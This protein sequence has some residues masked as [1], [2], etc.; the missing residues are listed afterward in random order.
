MK[1]ISLFTFV[2]L[3]C[4]ISLLPFV[5]PAKVHADPPNLSVTPTSL[6]ATVEL[7]STATLSLTVTNTGSNPST[8]HLYTGYPPPAAPAMMAAPLSIPV[9]LPQQQE[10]ID[11]DLQAEL[12]NGTTHFLVFFADRPDL[13]AAFLIRDWEA[14]GE[15]VYQ[16]L[17]SHAERSQRRVRAMLD[18]LGVRYQPLWIVNALLVEGDATLAQALAAHSDV[19]MLTADHEL[20]MTP[21]VT[22]STVSCSATS[23][24]VCWNIARIGADRVWREFGVT[25]SGITV[26]NIDSGVNY[27]HPAL[28][29]QYR[30]NLGGGSFDHNYNWFDPVGNQPAPVDS[31]NHGTHVMG[32]MVADPPGQ[33]AMGVAP[34]AR[35]IAARA[36]SK[37]NCNDSDIIAAAQWMLAPTDLNGNNPRP[38]LRPHVLNNSWAFDTGGNQVY[39]GYATAWQAAGIFVVFAAGNINSNF[40]GCSSV[41]SPSDYPNVVA[42]GATDQNDLVTYF[43]RIGPTT[44]GRIKPDL[45]APGAGIVATVSN[46]NLYGSLSGTSMAAPHVAGAVALLWAAKPELIGDYNATYSL[47]TS[48]ALPITVDNRYM[49]SSHS[50]CRPTTVPNN[51]YGYGRLDIFKAV[52]AARVTVPWLVLPSSTSPTLASNGSLDIEITLDA[53]RVAGPG[54][55]TARLLIYDNDLTN[56]PIVVPVTMTVPVRATHATISGTV[57]DS[58]T[59][60]PLRGTVTTANG[61]TVTTNATGVYSMTVPGGVT[62]HLTI[63]ASG[64]APYTQSVTPSAGSSV[65]LNAALDP[66]RPRLT[67]VQDLLTATVDFNQTT[68]VTLPLRNDGNLPL[69]YTLQ[70]DPEPYGVWRSDEPDGPTGGW[71]D[72]P[73][74]AQNLT[75]FDDGTSTG[76]DL[77][78]DFPFGGAYYRTIY[79]SA[80]GI[81][82][83]APFSNS[84]LYFEPRCLPLAETT[85]PAIVPL[86]VDF[87]S[88]EGGQINIA[89]MSTGALI[90]WDNVP[91]YGTNR[92]LSVQ[93]LLQSNGII[94]FHYRNVANL[95]KNDM[96]AIGLQLGEV[97][98]SIACDIAGTKQ[99]PLTLTDGLVVELRP[100]INPQVWLSIT[101]ASSGNINTGEQIDVQLASRWIG[102]LY[103]TQQARLRIISNDPQR[104]VTVARIRLNEGNPAPYQIILPIIYR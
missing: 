43:S 39:S 30:G 29:N 52:A 67:V 40:T 75:L 89:R 53:R 18:A 27:T 104:P 2:I 61:L 101:S 19:A 100:Q 33:P 96:G 72:P 7:G 15:Y 13:G 8:I 41:A 31:G 57:T 78:F 88:A 86:H 91:I 42:V 23:N 64:F 66:L 65:T 16:T 63:S 81:I 28:V 47:L 6:S 93:A 56:P 68:P 34:G 4:L 9:P 55:Y 21:P 97:T 92:R 62:Q 98:Q 60:N 102:P 49:G 80:N 5:P 71:I 103:A 90:T 77:G 48:T 54:I 46:S 14:R 10:R 51:I 25:G 76:I 84:T 17:T 3:A 22:T 38:S 73:L 74:D 59:D 35:W 94:R 24:N 45:V 87:N 26:A 95:Q 99:L 69:S 50:N 12:R 44:D 79:I 83:F 1:R 37:T 36:C 32:I 58:E 20:Q 70:I 82:A 11:P 85:A